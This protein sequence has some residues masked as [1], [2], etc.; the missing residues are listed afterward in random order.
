MTF[1]PVI[2]PSPQPSP[3]SQE[4]SR[5]VGELVEQFRREHPEMNASEIH[6]ALS[7]ASTRAGSSKGLRTALLLGVALL[8]ALLVFTLVVRG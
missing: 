2:I 6:Q 3:R 7:M 1:I 8:T 5:R 4:L